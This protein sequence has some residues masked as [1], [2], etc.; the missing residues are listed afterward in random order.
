[1]AGFAVVEFRNGWGQGE[2]EEE[3]KGHLGLD[4]TTQRILYAAGHP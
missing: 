2:G 4:K 3:V 1:M